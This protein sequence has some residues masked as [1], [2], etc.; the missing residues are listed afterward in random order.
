MTIATLAPDGG[1]DDA[2]ARA[3]RDLDDVAAAAVEADGARAHQRERDAVAD[4]DVGGRRFAVAIA[5]FLP[6]ARTRGGGEQA[7]IGHDDADASLRARVEHRLLALEAPLRSPPVSASI[8]KI[9]L[10]MT[11]SSSSGERGLFSPG[12]PAGAAT[13]SG[14]QSSSERKAEPRHRA[15]G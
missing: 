5:R 1:V 14:S 2:F 11:R 12:A 6:G 8:A 15:A 13:T 9:C 4:L 3:D 7:V 10:P